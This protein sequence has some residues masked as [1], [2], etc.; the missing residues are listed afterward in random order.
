[1]FYY[2]KSVAKDAFLLV[3]GNMQVLSYLQPISFLF[4]YLT[5]ET[6]AFFYLLRISN[7][8][9]VKKIF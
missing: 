9:V 6:V 5:K 4:I 7:I 1:M 2:T 8:I 3:D